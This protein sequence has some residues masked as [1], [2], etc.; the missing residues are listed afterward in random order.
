M[1]WWSLWSWLPES[2]NGCYTGEDR[3]FWPIAGWSYFPHPNSYRLIV[4][5]WTI[6]SAYWLY[7]TRDARKN[8]R[9]QWRSR[10]LRHCGIYCRTWRSYGFPRNIFRVTPRLHYTE[11]KLRC[12][13]FLSSSGNPEFSP[14]SRSTR[15]TR[16]VQRE[17][18]PVRH[19]IVLSWKHGQRYF[20]FSSW[21][22][23]VLWS[24][25]C[26]C[27]WFRKCLRMYEIA[28]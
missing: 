14:T 4:M 10:R 25:S 20:V 2:W 18:R 26:S 15:N 24:F 9:L 12:Y 6:P 5:S 8:A 16:R 13:E 27:Y 22:F 7:R 28:M 1:L 17:W 21:L 11:K 3:D 23:F 19:S